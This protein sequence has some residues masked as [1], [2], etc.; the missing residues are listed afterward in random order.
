[1]SQHFATR[2]NND[3]ATATGCKYI[4]FTV[5][6]HSV[7]SSVESLL[8]QFCSIKKYFPCAKRTIFFYWVSHDIWFASIRLTNIQYFF[9]GGESNPVWSEIIYQQC[10]CSIGR[11]TVNAHDI[12][13]ANGTFIASR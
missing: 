1:P 4:S 8:I 7:G 13:F 5:Y 10:N 11:N 12:A 2:R 9:I 6:F 3:D